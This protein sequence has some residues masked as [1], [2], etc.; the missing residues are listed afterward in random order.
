MR[1]TGDQDYNRVEMRDGKSAGGRSQT[2]WFLRQ[3]CEAD[4]FPDFIRR[5]Q[6]PSVGVGNWQVSVVTTATAALFSP[7]RGFTQVMFG[8][9]GRALSLISIVRS[10]GI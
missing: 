7:L 4:H 9:G 1:S 2:A 3:M 8:E 10:S 6:S 5:I